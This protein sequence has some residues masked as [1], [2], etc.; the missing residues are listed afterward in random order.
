MSVP[1]RIAICPG[2]YDPVTFGH[3]D[4]I[5]RASRLFDE[6]IVGVVGAPPRKQLTFSAAERVALIEGELGDL[7][8]VSV[9]VFSSLV[10]H[11]AVERGATALVKGLRAISDFDYE[12]Q[13]SQLNKGMV[14]DLETVFIMSSAEF[15]FVSSSGVKEIASFGGNVDELVPAPVARAFARLYPPQATKR[16]P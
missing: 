9:E 16:E 14:P 10:V 6:I 2:T 12:F 13:M 5:T 1:P 8:N 11:Y 7:P 15:S 4:I 3:L